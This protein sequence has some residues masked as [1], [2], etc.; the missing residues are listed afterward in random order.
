MCWLLLHTGLDLARKNF[1][2]KVLVKLKERRT[3]G[4]ELS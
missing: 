2:P 1:M 3:I 4:N